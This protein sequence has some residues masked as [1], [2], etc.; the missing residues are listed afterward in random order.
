MLKDEHIIEG[1]ISRLRDVLKY[2]CFKTGSSRELRER[3]FGSVLIGSQFF[4]KDARDEPQTQ[5]PS[6]QDDCCGQTGRMTWNV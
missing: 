5:Q 4:G 3:G 2:G 1:L 6:N